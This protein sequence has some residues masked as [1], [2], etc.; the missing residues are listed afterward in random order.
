MPWDNKAIEKY[1]AFTKNYISTYKKRI[2]C[3]DL[4]ISSLVEFA[5]EN[6]LPL[7][8]KYYDKGWKWYTYKPKTDDAK[9]FRKLAM[10][11]L[12]ARNVIDNTKP[13]SLGAAK[14]GDLI[15]SRWTASQGGGGHARIIYSISLD[16]K[17]K[18][19][20]VVWY[21]GNIPVIVPEKKT[22]LFSKIDSVYGGS[23]RRWNFEQFDK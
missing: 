21:Q 12:G 23:P 17:T 14:P 3:A 16:S 5:A 13:I 20:T 8:L 11:M 1:Q 4:A 22:D 6:K 18:K 2:D 19:Y 9:K 7:R 10:R 15:M